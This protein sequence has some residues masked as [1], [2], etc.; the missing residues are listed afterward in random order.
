MKNADLSGLVSIHIRRYISGTTSP[1]A[2][3][4]VRA[5][6]VIKGHRSGSS[7]QRCAK[8]ALLSLFFFD[9]NIVIEGGQGNI[10]FATIF[11]N[12]SPLFQNIASGSLQ[13]KQLVNQIQARW[14]MGDHKD[15]ASSSGKY[16]VASN[17]LMEDTDGSFVVKRTKG[18]VEDRHSMFCIGSPRKSDTLSLTA[19]QI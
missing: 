5:C 13:Y 18:I 11:I 12:V 19:T 8:R 1:V 9:G 10:E 6:S 17:Q 2:Y 7:L 15:T 14:K 4:E 16:A 3:K